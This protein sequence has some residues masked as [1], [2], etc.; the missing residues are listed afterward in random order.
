M[1]FRGKFS[2]PTQQQ[3]AMLGELVSEWSIIDHCVTAVLARL[4]GTP[5][6]LG[7]ALTEKLGHVHRVAALRNLA[8]MHERRYNGRKIPFDVLASVKYIAKQLDETKTP[9]NRTAHDII[10][11]VDDDT[12]FRANIRARHAPAHG[13]AL[14]GMVTLTNAEMAR[15]VS[16][17]THLR[18]EIEALLELLPEV[19]E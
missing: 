11:R 18:E 14:P 2:T 10:V 19:A 1:S 9:R 5:D 4:A 3:F 8:D 13:G 16:A 7:L 17:A 12:I 6:F 15:D